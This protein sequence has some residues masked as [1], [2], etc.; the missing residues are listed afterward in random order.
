MFTRYAVDHFIT[1][2]TTQGI[3]AFV[4]VF[5]VTMIAVTFINYFWFTFVVKIEVGVTKTMRAALFRHF[6][7]LSVDFFSKNSVGYLIGRFVSDISRIAEFASWSAQVCVYIIALTIAMLVFMFS[8]SWQL[9]LIAIVMIPVTVGLTWIVEPRIV[10]L[11]RRSRELNSRISGAFNEGITGAKT[12]KTLVAEGKF[13][14]DFKG[15]TGKMFTASRNVATLNGVWQPILMLIG[16]VAVGSV[17]YRGGVLVE[18]DL[19]AYGVLAAFISYAR[20]F[21]EPLSQI[22]EVY[23]EMLSS[24]TSLERAMLLMDTA[25]S[26]ADSPEVIEKYGDAQHPRRE[27][28]EPLHGDIEFRNVSFRYPDTEQYILRDFSLN[29]PRGSS[30]AIVG[31]TGAGKSTIVNLACRF[32]EP[33]SG[34]IL[35]DGTD[36]RERSV[37]WLHSNLGYVLQDPHLFSGTIR[38]N[39]RYGRLDATDA[40]VET[41]ARLVSA[42]GVANRCDKG[43]DTEVGEG[44][45]QLSTG[46]KQLVSFAR[47]VLANP[48]L[49]VLDE[50]TSSID[51]ETE[52]LIQDAISR[53]LTGRTSFIIAHRLSTIV[54]C[55]LIL[56]VED[57]EIVERGTHA[58]LIALGGRYKALFDAMRL[59][60]AMA[61]GG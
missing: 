32:F 48:P 55:D 44:G 20:Q 34:E 51:T 2:Q 23:N 21:V 61:V 24:Q 43:Y 60:E 8:L 29:V 35:I 27:N 7:D 14:R 9:G 53:V 19:M 26:V 31:E 56:V 36:Y 17:L 11:S 3:G 38:D 39:I 12:A 54:R 50:A 33:T 22:A 5:S 10:K 52:R 4:A 46:E 45:A 57:G 41:A 37:L 28:W 18:K 49:F 40:E 25:I 13:T 42:D 6:Q 15:L 1:A 59:E 30:V 58:E 47:A 16:T